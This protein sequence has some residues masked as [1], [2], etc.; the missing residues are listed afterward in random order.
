MSGFLA[1]KVWQSNLPPDLKPLAAALADIADHDGTSIYPSVAYLAWLLG[2]SDRA[3][4]MGLARLRG[5][6]VIVVVRNGLGGRFK[7]TEYRM[8]EGN[9]PRRPPWRNPEIISPFPVQKGEICDRK[10]RSLQQVSANL[11]Q[12]RAKPTS[13]DPLVDPSEEPPLNKNVAADAAT[14]SPGPGIP[15][16]IPL[17]TWLDYV[18]MRKKIRRPMTDGAVNLAI[19]TLLELKAAGH[20]PR[21]ILE[22]SIFNSW[23]GLFPVQKETRRANGK[24]NSADEA[25]ERIRRNLRNSGLAR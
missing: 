21:E 15:E 2:R 16:C 7:T 3:V 12:E 6:E 23:Q 18:A 19:K 5:L 25:N 24:R 13:P 8:V 14:S 22:Q 10:P 1:G 17:P 9:L 4:Q 11:T 20:D